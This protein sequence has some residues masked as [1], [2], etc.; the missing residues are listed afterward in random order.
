MATVK[1]TPTETYAKYQHS[2]EGKTELVNFGNAA[3]KTVKQI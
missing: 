2:A 1:S 3:D